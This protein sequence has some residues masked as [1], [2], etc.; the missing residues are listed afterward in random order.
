MVTLD[1]AAVRVRAAQLDP[2]KVLVFVLSLP[3]FVLGFT[4]RG[5]WFVVSLFLAAGMEGWDAAGQQIAA[6][7]VDRRGG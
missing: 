4:L 3:L 6:R 1:A 5:L 7:Q 2:V